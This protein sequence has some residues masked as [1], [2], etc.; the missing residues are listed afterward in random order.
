MSLDQRYLCPLVGQI[1]GTALYGLY[2]LMMKNQ[3]LFLLTYCII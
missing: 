2:F 3:Q 1:K